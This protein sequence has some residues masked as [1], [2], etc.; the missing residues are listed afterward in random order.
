MLLLCVCSRYQ[1]VRLAIQS[2]V[3]FSFTQPPPRELLLELA[4]KKNNLPLP[5]I[6]DK[7]GVLLPE[8][9]VRSCIGAAPLASATADSFVRWLVRWLVLWFNH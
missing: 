5:I 6:P 7:L 2:R 1:D 8:D 4:Q 3:N 9:E